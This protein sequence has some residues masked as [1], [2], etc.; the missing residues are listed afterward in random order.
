MHL[1]VSTTLSEGY[2]IDCS[3]SLHTLKYLKALIDN[4]TGDVRHVLQSLHLTARSTS[5]NGTIDISY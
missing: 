2:V 4:I 1:Q 3:L 5:R